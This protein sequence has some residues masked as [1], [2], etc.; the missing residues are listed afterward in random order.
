MSKTKQAGKTAQGSTRRGK[1][2]GVKVFGGQ[3]AKT[4]SIIVRQRGSKFHPGS[5]VKMGRDHTIYAMQNGTVKFFTRTGKK[6]V[7]VVA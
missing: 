2:L 7:S 1:R 4:G 5:G 6:F 3:S